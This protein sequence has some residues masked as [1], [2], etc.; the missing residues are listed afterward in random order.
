MNTKKFQWLIFLTSL[1]ITVAGLSI[2]TGE[3][4]AQSLPTSIGKKCSKIGKTTKTRSGKVLVCQKSGKAKVWKVQKKQ[5]YRGDYVIMCEKFGSRFTL[6][7]VNVASGRLSEIVA[8]RDPI[9]L[10]RN[11]I[12]F[13]SNCAISSDMSRELGVKVWAGLVQTRSVKTGKIKTLPYS[14]NTSGFFDSAPPTNV[15]STICGSGVGVVYSL[16]SDGWVYQESNGLLSRK[17]EASSVPN[18][19]LETDRI[20]SLVCLGTEAAFSISRSREL[21]PDSDGFPVYEEFTEIVKFDGTVVTLN[22]F[23]GNCFDLRPALGTCPT[24]GT[25]WQPTEYVRHGV[26]LYFVAPSAEG[27][28]LWTCSDTTAFNACNPQGVVEIPRS[29]YTSTIVGFLSGGVS[30]LIDVDH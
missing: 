7:L 29:V 11:D 17:L 10:S 21:P 8:R 13:S 1:A 20:Q 9:F 16:A 14:Q 15:S 23:G 24:S 2:P 4:N 6:Y 28:Y 26:S 3:T 27:K 25:G 12:R 30:T 18:T 22:E 19:Q 5:K